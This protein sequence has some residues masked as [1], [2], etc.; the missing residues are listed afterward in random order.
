MAFRG[1][2]DRVANCGAM[3]IITFPGA[4]GMAFAFG[5]ESAAAN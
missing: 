1:F 4:L 3:R 2:A 5:H